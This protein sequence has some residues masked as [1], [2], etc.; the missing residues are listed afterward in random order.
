[1]RSTG[2]R[3]KRWKKGGEICKGEVTGLGHGGYFGRYLTTEGVTTQVWIDKG[4]P[5]LRT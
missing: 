2:S 3:V 4:T 1:M 5:S